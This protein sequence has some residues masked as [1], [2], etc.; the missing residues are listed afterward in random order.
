M[1]TETAVADAVTRVAERVATAASRAGRDPSEVRIV[2]ATKEADVE[3]IASA[4]RAGLR[5]FGENR[6]REL[7]AKAEASAGDLRWH[8][9]GAVQTNK[10]RFLDRVVLVHGLDRL[11]E[12][13]ALQARGDKLGRSW[14]VLVEVNI[15]AEAQKQGIPAAGLPAFLDGLGA[16]PRVR[17]RGLMFVA[18]HV[19]NPEDVRTMFG[20][21]R[22]LSERFGLRELS[23]GM[24]DDFE[25]AV[26][27]GST[28]VRIGRAIFRPGSE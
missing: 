3:A 7:A 1:K 21:A 20:E 8:Y 9:L 28:M 18:P 12:A 6:A 26:E 22:S 15:A 5:D 2:A 11:R 14:D 4:A 19:E 25:V 23:M 27:E 17:P 10:V 16:Y 24:S 13:E